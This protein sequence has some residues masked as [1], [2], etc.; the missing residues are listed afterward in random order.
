M[1]NFHLISGFA[2]FNCRKSGVIRWINNQHFQMK[3][4]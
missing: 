4:L 3:I 2:A 1:D